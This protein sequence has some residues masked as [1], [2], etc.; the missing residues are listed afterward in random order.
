MSRTSLRLTLTVLALLIAGGGWRLVQS[1]HQ[2]Q[3]ATEVE[4]AASAA[5]RA[6]L[7]LAP[8]DVLTV[9]PVDMGRTVPVSGS[10]RAVSTAWVKAKVAGELVALTPREGDT[11]QAGQVI[12]RI[13]PREYDLRVQQAERNADAARAQVDIT[14]RQLE[15][16][17]ALVAQGF[18]SPTAVDTAAANDQAARASLK[19]AQSAVD[20]ARKSLGDAQLRAPISGVVSQRLAQ[21]GERVAID[22]KVIEIVDLAKL[23]LEAAIA[24]EDAVALRPGLRAR[25]SVE[26]MGAP[27]EATVARINPSTQ[28]GSR[29]VLTYLSVMPQPGLRSGLFA[30]GSIEVERHTA[31]AV[32]VTAV[33]VDDA[34]PQLLILRDRPE[35]PSLVRRVPVQLGARGLARLAQDGIGTSESEVVEILSGVQTGDRVLLASVGAVADNTTARVSPGQGTGTATPSASAPTP[36][37][38]P[39]SASR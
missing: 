26:G 39:A 16:N 34:S 30:R 8:T 20:L 33:R 24:P 28:A 31:L 29:A 38:T 5:Q 27:L 7:E 32:T 1:R 14:R 11:V 19:A 37:G 17:R 3:A 4:R 18:V 10:L 35:G 9:G 36:G 15:N 2:A 12:G 23:E 13:E 25:L 22:A 6:A 21:P